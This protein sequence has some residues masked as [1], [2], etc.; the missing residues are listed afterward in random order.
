MITKIITGG[1]IGIDG[2]QV[3]VEIDMAAGMPSFDIVGLPDSS[4]KESKERVRSA[5]KNN[6][7]NLPDKR[8]TI[9]L[10][11][12][13]TRKEGSY[14]DLPIAVG[15]MAHTGKINKINI[16]DVFF[17]G[18][19]SLDGYLRPMNGLLP[20]VHQC[21]SLG[22]TRFAVP[23]ENYREASL[24]Q[25]IEVVGI[26]H[27]SDVVK[28]FENHEKYKHHEEFLNKELDS[29]LDFRHVRGQEN[30]IRA[31]TV[32]AAGG[33]NILLI[34]PP[35]SGKT[36][37]AKR[38]PT[39]LPDLTLEESITTTKIYSVS[40]QLKN[41][42]ELVK[43]RPFRAPHHTISYAALVG[44]G[45]IIKPGE[46][47]LSHNGVLFLDELPEF[48]RNVLEVMRQPL[49]DREVSISRASGNIVYPAG[50]MLVAS[51][52]PC[53][54]GN[55]GNG[56]KCTCSTL[57]ISKYLHKISG[58]LLD[59]IDIHIEASRIE[60][61]DLGAS[62]YKSKNTSQNLKEKVIKAREKQI[63]RY[64]TNKLNAHMS[65]SDIDQYC[66]LDKTSH[67]ILEQAFDTFGLSARAYHKIL[68]LA[69]TI[70]DID[71][72]ENIE[73]MHLTEAIQY[74]G[75]DRKYFSL[76]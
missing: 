31:M 49:E 16:S 23:V 44:G 19:L 39:I 15:I 60:Y 64:R 29:E 37:M 18:E 67:G 9:N 65:T 33:H 61:K 47:S 59:R 42:N 5:L 46:I 26:K 69:R 6:G 48:N 10:A 57:Q 71:E 45:R 52:N 12:A 17:A 50:F 63:N 53:P 28:Y 14:F 24:I 70:A 7:Y 55:Y 1:T 13:D 2:Y 30:V 43:V 68:K 73:I 27:I 56:N 22:I 32:A 8:I 41:R 38:I 35:G 36:M 51:M 75:L 25:D 54:C 58:P 11:P 3:T 34:G 4:I 62:E 76:T 40:G 74:R 21:A 66:Q 72:K 20:M